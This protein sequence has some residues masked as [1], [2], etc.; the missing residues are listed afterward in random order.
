M[1]FLVIG[2][3]GQLGRA[4]QSACSSE[5][6]LTAWGRSQAE[7]TSPEIEEKIIQLRPDVVIN[8][9]AWT[10]VD[11]AEKEADSAFAANALGAMYVAQAC[12]AIGASL[13]HVSTNEVFAGTPGRFYYEYDETAPSSIY[14]RSKRA[15]EVAVSRVLEQLYIVRVAWL[16]G[17]GGNS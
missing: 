6:A 11:G 13:V 12:T 5:H 4:I 10:N 8:C 9:A 1:H 7:I 3:Q 17:P 2:A 15:G 14:A 16:F